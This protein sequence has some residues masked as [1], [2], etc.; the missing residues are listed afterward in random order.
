LRV[1][2]AKLFGEG[3]AVLSTDDDAVRLVSCGKEFPE[4]AIRIFKDDVEVSEDTVGEIR[5]K[6]PSLM[7]RYWEDDAQTK[8]AFASGWLKTGGLG[9]LHEGR[10]YVCGRNKEVIITNGRNFYPQDIEW[11]AS[12]V[13]GVRKG[14]VIAFGTY[15]KPPDGSAEREL[16]VLVFETQASADA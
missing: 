6:G 13:A 10:L 7:T 8:Q 1:D 9:F 12:R 14:N 16:V 4:H 15:Y 2:G 5:I 3:K 11:E